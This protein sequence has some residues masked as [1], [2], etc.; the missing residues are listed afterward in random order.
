MSET[1]YLRVIWRREAPTLEVCRKDDFGAI[2][3]T[4]KPAAE[5]EIQRL[6]DA[7]DCMSFIAGL[8]QCQA[9]AHPDA[10]LSA[11]QI[12]EIE[13][14]DMER[15]EHMRLWEPMQPPAGVVA[16]GWWV[17]YST[18]QITN[19]AARARREVVAAQM[20]MGALPSEVDPMEAE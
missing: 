1:I 8:V 4:P 19:A 7:L 3:Y 6:R 20:I 16:L 11:A 17:P 2:A 13:R 5:E 15:R 10:G 9:A 12:K 14:L 18:A